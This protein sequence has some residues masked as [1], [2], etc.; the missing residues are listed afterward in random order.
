MILELEPVTPF[1]IKS[2]VKF[3]LLDLYEDNGELYRI[4]TEKFL[5]N[6]KD[7]EKEALWGLLDEFISLKKEG[8]GK[9]HGRMQEKYAEQWKKINSFNIKNGAEKY[10]ILPKMNTDQTFK[11]YL[12]FDDFISIEIKRGEVKELLPYIPGSTLKGMVRRM[13][14]LEYI[15]MKNKK[16]FNLTNN[17]DDKEDLDWAIKEVMQSI[18]ISDFYPVGKVEIK[19]EEVKR[20]ASNVLPL[21]CKGKFYGEINIESKLWNKGS[22]LKQFGIAG[23]KED[24]E[25]QLLR[26]VLKNSSLI[27]RKNQEFY[28]E[29]IY[30]GPVNSSDLIALGNGKGVSL[31]GFA[32]VKNDIKLILPEIKSMS[33]NGSVWVKQ[34]FP[35]SHWTVKCFNEEKFMDTKL[36]ILRVRKNNEYGHLKEIKEIV[37][38]VL[39]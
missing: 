38:E 8:K 29:K 22:K 12:D 25:E 36:G 32:A 23:N 27:I 28:K 9:G 19:M 5:K 16:P 13:L 7:E 24:M 10:K 18:Q 17:S 35:I 39:Q 30:F 26:I 20:A 4:D 21:I 34:N 14:M 37:K 1:I 2:G 33:K 31:S 6:L 3:S 11:R 15:S